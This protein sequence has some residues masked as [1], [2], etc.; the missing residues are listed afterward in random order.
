MEAVWNILK[1]RVRKREYN[2]IRELKHVLLEEWDRITM[3]EI[4]AKIDE[5]PW[6]CSEVVRTKGQGIKSL[7]W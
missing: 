6:R 7:L 2:S 1:Q 5:M 3:Q 4:R